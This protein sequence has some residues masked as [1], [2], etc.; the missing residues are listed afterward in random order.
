[1]KGY[2]Y[3]QS[4]PGLWTVGFYDPSGK[5]N[6]ESDHSSADESCQARALPQ[7]RCVMI[8]DAD[9]SV[10]LA[11]AP[12]PCLPWLWFCAGFTVAVGIVIIAL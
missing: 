8:D 6:P 12:S 11:D 7:R 5:W 10:I 9:Q 1:M 3:I 2:V 4:E